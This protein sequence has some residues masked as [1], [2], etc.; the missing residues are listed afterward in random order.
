MT[1]LIQSPWAMAALLLLYAIVMAV[2]TIVETKYSTITA[3]IYFYNSWWFMLLQIA[4]IANF[5]AMSLRLHLAK[6]RKWGALVLHYALATILAGALITHLV[7]REGI[8]HIREGETSNTLYNT[9]GDIIA[10]LPFNVTL[11]DFRLVRYP[12]SGSPSSYESDVVIDGQHEKIYM[13]NI[14]Y[15]DG[16]RLYQSS[17]DHDEQGTILSV[18]Q[19]AAGT[20]ITYIGY[21][22][23]VLGMVMALFHRNSRFRHLIRSLSVITLVFG[24]QI[25]SAQKQSPAEGALAVEYAQNAA[26]SPDVAEKLGHLLIQTRS[27]RIE[28]ID[29]YSSE[30]LR[31]IS[32]EKSFAGLSANQILL[33]IVTSPE[34]W[35]RIPFIRHNSQMIAFVDVLDTAG[36]Y[37]YAKQVEQTYEKPVSQRNK[38]DKELLKLDEKINILHSLF[39][40]EM[41]QIFPNAAD[42]SHK[43]YSPGDDISAFTGQDSMFVSRIFVWLATEAR[44][45]N[46]EKVAEIIDM[47]QTYQHAK[48]TG[49]DIDKERIEAEMLYNRIDIFK[50]SAFAYMGIGLAL[51]ALIIINL[52]NNT[53]I[54]RRLVLL[55]SVFIVGIFLSHS[56]GIGLRWYISGRAPMS[57]AY[58]SMVYVSWAT[59]LS[60]LLF[61]HRSKMTL[62]LAA[63]FAG[64]ILFVTN[65]NFMD[66]EIT[67]L[68]PVLKS[69][70]LMIHVAVI[71]GSYGFFG[72]G[73]LLGLTSL[74]L[75]C[76][77]GQRMQ[78]QIKELYVMNQL[79]L[80]IGLVLL[81]AG[82]FL[83]AVWANESWGRYWGWDPKETWALIT[84]IVYTLITHSYFIPR[85][86]TPY[87][88][89]IMSIIGL[90]SVL[91]TFFGVNYYLSG[92]HSY[93]GDSAPP[94]LNIIYVVYAAIAI[95]A[96]VAYKRL[97]SQEQ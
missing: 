8:M 89:A 13:N 39:A 40:G 4:M 2:A 16:Y 15:K 85:L 96:V 94:A 71:T 14:V 56:F 19:D 73:F 1:K 7:G 81:T 63:F 78:R 20:I 5:V 31:K 34:I 44:K 6:Q 68:V 36:N 50:W 32:R 70:W 95:L 21:I 45:G 74:I 72:I 28:P 11:T 48:A 90:T 64:V 42:P 47:I 65:L 77:G 38:S 92:L 24:C 84:M 27:G 58:E 9:K 91:M 54:T 93:G 26:I 87:N 62:A 35:S 43:W 66:P 75:M 61:T 69:Y 60:G 33:G 12:G 88:F 18:N 80:T 79:S 97:N 22:M 23:L 30:I 82:T 55:F 86:R 53:L 17:Y 51:L 52:L 49:V 37:I 46:N 59:A 67:P 57:N 83:G 29:T 76:I 41:L 3:R 25:A 10:Q